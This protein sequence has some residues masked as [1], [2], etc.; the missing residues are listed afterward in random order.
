MFVL[1]FIGMS[2]FSDIFNSDEIIIKY[3]IHPFN[4]SK[5]EPIL[6]NNIKLLFKYSYI[7][8]SLIISNYLANIIKNNITI[9]N[10]SFKNK[11]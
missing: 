1:N 11:N 6:W 7:I 4:I 2:I 9:K 5:E 10:K 8:A 3:A